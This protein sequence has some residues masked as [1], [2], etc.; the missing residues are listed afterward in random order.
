[1]SQLVGDWQDFPA[2][3]RRTTYPLSYL[4]AY[5]VTFSGSTFLECNHNSGNQDAWLI[6]PRCFLSWQFRLT[7]T[8][9]LGCSFI[10]HNNPLNESDPT[11]SNFV[12]RVYKLSAGVAA[13]IP[14][15][16]MA[17]LQLP[18]GYCYFELLAAQTNL[19]VNGHLKLLSL[20]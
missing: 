16:S 18:A 12:W 5:S 3:P 1:M 2:D 14:Q 8:A 15:N 20:P 6:G 17:M 9:H 7:P 11:T 4:S 19:T 10:I 13:G